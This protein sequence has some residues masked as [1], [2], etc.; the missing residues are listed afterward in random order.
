MPDALILNSS[1]VSDI[2]VK[3]KKRASTYR[4]VSKKTEG[5]IS[6]GED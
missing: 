6:F 3:A 2:I 4:A 5:T 1:D